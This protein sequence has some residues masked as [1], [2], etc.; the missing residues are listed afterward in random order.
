MLALLRLTGE[1]VDYLH[2]KYCF[3][4][5]AKMNQRKGNRYDLYHLTPLT[6]TGTVTR[7]IQIRWRNITNMNNKIRSSSKALP[8]CTLSVFISITM[9]VSQ[10][11]S[12]KSYFIHTII[13]QYVFHIDIANIPFPYPFPRVRG[14]IVYIYTKELVDRGR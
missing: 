8:S 11:Q 10:T 5:C 3:R 1:F 6:L 7:P 2:S 12:P 14:I 9:R 13:L 4:E